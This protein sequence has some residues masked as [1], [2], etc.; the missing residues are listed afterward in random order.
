MAAVKKKSNVVVYDYD[1]WISSVK[2]GKSVKLVPKKDFKGSIR[3][4]RHLLKL[5]LRKRKIRTDQKGPIGTSVVDGVLV[6]KPRDPSRKK[7]TSSNSR[8]ASLEK[9]RKK[10]ENKD[11]TV[12]SS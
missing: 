3:T 2:S 10:K 8:P 1:K 7:S 6:L 4:M 9:K 12:I 5:A 11:T